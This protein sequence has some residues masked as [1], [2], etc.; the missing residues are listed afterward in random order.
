M[1]CDEGK[2]AE[3]DGRTVVNLLRERL[4]KRRDTEGLA[5]VSKLMV[6]NSELECWLIV[7]LHPG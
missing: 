7:A 4:T 5:L 6:R 1:P 3:R 2:G